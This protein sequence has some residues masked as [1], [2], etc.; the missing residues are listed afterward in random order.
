MF[1]R[2]I[3]VSGA[4]FWKT[5]R[6]NRSF[7]LQK[8]KG[9]GTRGLS[10]LLVQTWDSVLDTKP[11]PYRILYQEEGAE[12]FL[13]LS[14]CLSSQEAM[15]DW[16]WLEEEM[17]AV[18]DKFETPADITDFV[19]GKVASIVAS[20][21]TTE[22]AEAGESESYKAARSK[23]QKLFNICM[24]SD[25]LV[26][27]YSATYWS[28]RLPAQGWVYLTVNHLA[29]YSFLLGA[30]T[31]V[32]VR[33]TDVTNIARQTGQGVTV[34]TRE[35]SW[36]FTLYNNEGYELI[37]QLA[38]LA[39]RKLIS[40]TD[41]Y[42]QDLDLLLKKTKNVT[43]KSFVKRDLDARKKTEAYVSQFSL[44]LEEK[45]DGKVECFLFTPYNKKYRYV[46]IELEFYEGF[47]AFSCSSQIWYT[48][49][50]YKFLLLQL[51]CS[52]S[53]KLDIF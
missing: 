24:D 42:H 34:E 7:I 49:F 47:N 21:S 6:V 18:L 32:L 17:V 20:N 35:G 13:L 38:N 11:P 46:N 8:R 1:P 50:E 39:M 36:M 14:A 28:G 40:D 15:T 3:L 29:F 48:V 4:G 23:V 52:G 51:P 33:W 27:Y 10:S 44:P 45:L 9:H 37:S 16:A 53:C 2:E 5:E 26:S 30:E 12:T 31:K 22:T 41:S 43:K 25:R 19:T